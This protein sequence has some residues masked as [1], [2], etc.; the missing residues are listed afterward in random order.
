MRSGEKTKGG[1]QETMD[2]SSAA[3]VL[4]PSRMLIIMIVVFWD[5]CHVG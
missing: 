2:E 1:N 3:V 4:E 5:H